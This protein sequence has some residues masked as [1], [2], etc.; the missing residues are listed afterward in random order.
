MNSKRF[1]LLDSAK[2]LITGSAGFI[3][4]HVVRLFVRK[5]P[6]FQIFNLNAL[7]YAGN[8]ENPADIDGAENYTFLT[9]NINAA[10]S[11]SDKSISDP[12][13]F[14]KANVVG[15]M[16]LLNAAKENWKD[17]FEDKLFYHIGGDEV[18]GNLWD[19]GLFSKKTPY[20]PNSPY[21]ASKTTSDHG[22][23][24]YGETFNLP[25]IITNYY[26]DYGSNQVP[27]KLFPLFVP[28]I[29]NER[30]LPMYG[31]GKYAG[32]YLYMIEQVCVIEFLFF[33][34]EVEKTVNWYPKSQNWMQ[35]A[36]SGDYPEYNDG[37]FLE[38][39]C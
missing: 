3:G 10:E 38:Y 5:Y 9:A 18:Y 1:R 24:F 19:S 22:V 13:T 26:N 15:I 34:G 30:P 4:S 29:I 2:I 31:D 37:L 21:S 32:D 27:E 12:L 39:S 6:H 11:H 28:N 36:T 35:H 23:R 14:V 8:L 33:F 17:K 20:D 7:T 25:Y 16:N